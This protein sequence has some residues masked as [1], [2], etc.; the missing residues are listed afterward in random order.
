MLSPPQL[1]LGSQEGDLRASGFT[2]ALFITPA[3]L[4]VSDNKSSKKDHHDCSLLKTVSNFVA[5]GFAPFAAQ[6]E[7][8]RSA[9]Q[10]GKENKAV[11][12]NLAGRDDNS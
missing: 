9:E 8:C 4:D 1:T 10:L 11:A 2:S 5:E 6:D 7:S 3:Q 12:R